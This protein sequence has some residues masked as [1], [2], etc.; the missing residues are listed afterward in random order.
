MISVRKRLHSGLVVFAA[1]ALSV[2]VLGA[3]VALADFDTNTLHANLSGF[4]GGTPGDENADGTFDL[5][6]KPETSEACFAISV[7]LTD[8]A[9][10]PPTSIDLAAYVD[11]E[12]GDVVLHL[13]SS[14]D[15]EGAA[16]GCVPATAELLAAI[17][18][19]PADYIVAVY[20][21]GYPTGAAAGPLYDD[22]PYI[23]LSVGTKVCPPSIQS[24]EDLTEDTISS[25]LTVT[26]PG[27]EITVPTGYTMEGYGGT[28]TFD[29]HVVDEHGFDATIAAAELSGGGTCSSVTH[30]CNMSGFGYE[31]T[32]VTAGLVDITPTVIPAGLRFGDVRS[33][34]P[35]TIGDGNV[36]HFDATSADFVSATV[37]LFRSSD[38]T[39]PV[40]TTPVIRFNPGTFAIVAPV[41]VTWSG[42]DSGSGIARYVVQ[43]SL[44]GGAWVTVAF[45]LQTPSYT[46]NMAKGHSYRFR[47]RAVDVAG[48]IGAF[49]TTPTE[50]FRWVDDGSAQIVYAGNWHP[51]TTTTAWG[52]TLH[53]SMAAGSTARLT[54]SGRAVA[55][56]APIG[57]T[58]GKA[59]IYL[60]GVY[61]TTIDLYSS[62][63]L[64]RQIVYSRVFSTV[65]TRQ[66]TIKVVG[67][68]G[69]PRVDVDV[70]LVLY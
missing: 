32:G 70:F 26:L 13:A 11:G 29:Y 6:L 3:P 20:T 34:I 33:Q 5:T 9:G 49:K 50:R 62:T 60:N 12:I 44:D 35:L 52:D 64:S 63:R 17:A 51:S 16:S 53:Y 14:V 27:D 41:K 36:I 58:K 57:P 4:F 21:A 7:T 30:V 68:S 40:V 24:P 47:V 65:A 54:F 22:W 2:G 25:C 56:V 28:R 61:Q 10:D 38:V 43:R 46:T 19:S 69:R 48:N 23:P 45:N 39:P 42:S 8:L 15:S 1:I 59:K 67:T 18:A 31:W 66:L 37:Y 55:W